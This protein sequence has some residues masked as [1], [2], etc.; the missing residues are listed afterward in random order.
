LPTVAVFNPGKILKSLI[1]MGK[2]KD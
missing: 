2:W 1:I